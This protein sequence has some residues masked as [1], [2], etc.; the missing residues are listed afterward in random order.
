MTR[1]IAGSARGRRLVVPS[2]RGT[3]PTADR[4]REALFSTL[5]ALTGSLA[6]SRVLDL[7]A[8][9]GAIGL[10]ACS[11]GAAAALL[12]ESDPGAERAIR[13][14][15]EAVGLAG[16]TVQRTRV[17]RLVAG[18]AVGDTY[19]IAVL[20]P[21]YDLED[22]ALRAVLGDALAHGWLARHAVVAVERATRGGPWTW[23]PGFEAERSR[24]YGEATLWYG[25][26]GPSPG[27]E[28]P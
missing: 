2:G 21:P 18:T 25:H 24:T 20:D 17:E 3:R 22:D 14:N 15:I 12:V 27:P 4:A 19:D 28:P 13:A 26:A 23:P 5:E 6:G 8:G 16:V 9:S 10:E 11:R 7:Y 1:V